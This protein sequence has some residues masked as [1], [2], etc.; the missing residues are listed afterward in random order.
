MIGEAQS[1]GVRNDLSQNKI[2]FIAHLHVDV[3]GFLH[4]RDT[5]IG[6]A[7]CSAQSRTVKLLEQRFKSS[8][9]YCIRLDSFFEGVCGSSRQ[10]LAECV[11]G[12]PVN[13]FEAPMSGWSSLIVEKHYSSSRN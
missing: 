13:I 4:G 7:L 8:I 9:R 1:L 10:Q 12:P 2:N 11:P 5:T 6:C 3:L